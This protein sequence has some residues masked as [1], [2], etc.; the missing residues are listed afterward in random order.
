VQI[1][2]IALRTRGVARLE[3]VYARVLGLTVRL[4]MG[5]QGVWLAAGETV[6]M[7]EEAS[8]TEPS[9]SKG[10]VDLVASSPRRLRD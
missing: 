5:S 7:I 1:H 6:L 4:R 3:G 2:H 9:I 10:S 8:E